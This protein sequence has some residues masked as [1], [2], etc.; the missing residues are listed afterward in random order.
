MTCS[1]V[2]PWLGPL[3]YAVYESSPIMRLRDPRSEIIDR[4][5]FWLQLHGTKVTKPLVYWPRYR[6]LECVHDLCALA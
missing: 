5:T 1:P 6:G 4:N 3:T 2:L